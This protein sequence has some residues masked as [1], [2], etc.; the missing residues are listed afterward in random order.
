MLRRTKEMVEQIRIVGKS[1]EIRL[2]RKQEGV[3]VAAVMGM[4]KPEITK[5][6]CTPIQPN[7]A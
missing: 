6:I 2:R 3:E 1:L 5:K 4:T 7:Q